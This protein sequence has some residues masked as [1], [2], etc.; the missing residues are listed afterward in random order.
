MKR[1]SISCPEDLYSFT[2]IHP[3]ETITNLDK[4]AIRENGEAMIDLRDACPDILVR[5]LNSR[6]KDLKARA[7]VARRLNE[8]QTCLKEHAAGYQIVVVDAW[9]PLTQQSRWHRIA[10]AVIRLRHPFWPSELVR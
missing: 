6:T 10:K 9:R 4:I 7:S 3:A 1:Q 5:P 8:A 2:P